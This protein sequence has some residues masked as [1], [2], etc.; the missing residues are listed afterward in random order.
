MSN[1]LG[2]RTRPT[3]AGSGARVSQWIQRS[4]LR[5]I[6]R[7]L[8]TLAPGSLTAT[9]TI[10][11]VDPNTSELVYLGGAYSGSETNN[12]RMRARIAL[13]NATTIT[14]TR[15]DNGGVD[16]L[17]VQF[18]IRQYWPGYIRSVQRGTV[19]S[20]QAITAVTVAKSTIDQLGWLTTQTD[21]DCS[22]SLTLTNATTVTAA[23]SGT[24]T[25]VGYQVI[26]WY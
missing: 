25:T 14:A 6:E 13:T 23:I 19:T 2:P 3:G 8:I 20:T 1:R 21:G 17:V 18:E 5:S 24:G 7:G 15:T 26:E 4:M 12:A 11:S 22:A 9:A 16:N 10:T